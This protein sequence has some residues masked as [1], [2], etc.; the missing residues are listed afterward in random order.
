MK[1]R[2]LITAAAAVVLAFAL[3]QAFAAGQGPAPDTEQSRIQRGYQIA[4]VPLNLRGKNRALV[5]LG[6]YIVNAQGGCNDCHTNPPFAEGGNPHLGQP[7]RINAERYLAGGMDFGGGIISR[8]LTP[9]E[10]GKPAGL[11][12]AEFRQVLR[13]GVDLD[14]LEPHVPSFENDLLQVMPPAR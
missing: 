2:I 6:S 7:K 5:G 1:V 11:T 9:D 13:T 14:K 3:S 12:F 10:T 8:N 4:P